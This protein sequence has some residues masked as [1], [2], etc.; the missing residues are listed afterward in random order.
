[1]KLV[2]AEPIHAKRLKEIHIS[3]YQH[4]YR[5]FLPDDY[6]DN[7]KITPEIVSKTAAYIE[8]TESYFA[9]DQGILKAF[10]YLDYPKEYPDS[11]EIMAIYVHPDYHKSGVGRFL[12]NEL[13]Q[14]KKKDGFKNCVAWTM[15]NGPSIGFYE[16]NG[17]L[18]QNKCEKMWRFDVPIIM[19]KKEL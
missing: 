18:K 19:F 9:E 6:L 17:F 8:K 1:M 4:S 10:V 14:M 12:V 7:L 16:K 15:K 13:A 2:K 11:F 3:A 5:G